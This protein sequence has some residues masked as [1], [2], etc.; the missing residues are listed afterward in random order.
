MFLLDTNVLSEL[1]K[2][3]PERRVVT[4]LSSRVSSEVFVSAI[5]LGEIERGIAKV[6]QARP[7]FA[8]KLTAW[9]VGIVTDYGDRVL[10]V[11]AAVARR[12]GVLTHRV[13]HANADVLI[14]ATAIEHGLTIATRNVKHFEPTDAATFNPFGA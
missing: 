11:D 3:R 10:P 12:W 1:S 14:A 5:T 8:G 13:G 7:E 2:E 4:W 9:L 6:R